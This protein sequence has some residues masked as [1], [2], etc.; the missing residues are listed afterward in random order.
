M[1][2]VPAS[3]GD[4]G[5]HRESQ[6]D[7]QVSHGSGDETPT[8]M[9]SPTASLNAR[10]T[11]RPSPGRSSAD[12]IEDG[13]ATDQE[14]K[15]RF[16]PQVPSGTP[17]GPD[18]SQDLPDEGSFAQANDPSSTT[19]HAA[20]GAKS[21]KTKAARKKL[22]APDSDGEDRAV[23]K[24]TWSRSMLEL[25]Y[26]RTEL[27]EFLRGNPVMRIMQLELIG[28][29]TGPVQAPSS[30]TNKLDA[31][32][33]LL[34]LL[35]D[36]GFTAGVFDAEDLFHLELDAIRIS[37]AALFNLLKP[38]VG[39]RAA[40]QAPESKIAQAKSLAYHTGSSQYDSA[41]SEAGSNSS[42]RS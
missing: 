1:V 31:A 29:I 8:E 23:L 11:D 4:A 18:A 5:F 32:M 37:A 36:A 34:R 2:R 40:A 25:A 22:K 24:S 3:L 41:T 14:E 30:T 33:D 28:S 38:L 12:G 19:T 13:L 6:D 20:P 16:P 17:A 42:S 7:A 10:S 26:K 27:T 21:V 15:P 35:E 39:E 9:G